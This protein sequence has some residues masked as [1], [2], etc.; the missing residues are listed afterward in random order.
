MADGGEL[1]GDGAARPPHGSRVGVLAA[2][3]GQ[4]VGDG[5]W[6]VRVAVLERN[7]FCYLVH[8]QCL[9]PLAVDTWQGNRHGVRSL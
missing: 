8:P 6:A 9:H 5:G 1:V 7:G 4:V 2:E 3:V